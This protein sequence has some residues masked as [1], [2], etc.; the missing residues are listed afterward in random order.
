M[1]QSFAESVPF[2]AVVNPLGHES[3]LS[4]PS[5][6]WNVPTLHSIDLSPS[7]K[8][9]GGQFAIECIYTSIKSS[10]GYSIG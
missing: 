1:L 7:P 3:Q 2:L 6:A 10:L 5:V 9:P 4:D 8:N